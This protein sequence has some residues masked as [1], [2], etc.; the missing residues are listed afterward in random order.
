MRVAGI[1]G[2]FATKRTS[3]RCVC[4][5]VVDGDVRP[6]SAPSTGNY[7][8]RLAERTQGAIDGSLC[9]TVRTKNITAHDRPVLAGPTASARD[10]E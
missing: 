4:A 5:V 9:G 8:A 2:R 6:S 1:I 10:D 7:D 3:S